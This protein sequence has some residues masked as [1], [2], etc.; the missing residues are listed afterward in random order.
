MDQFIKFEPH[1]YNQSTIKLT[2]VANNSYI[3]TSMEKC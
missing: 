2:K 3:M 1:N